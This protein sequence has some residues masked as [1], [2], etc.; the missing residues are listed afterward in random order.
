MLVKTYSQNSITGD[1]AFSR[2]LWSMESFRLW[3][4]MQESVENDR[5]LW[6]V[7]LDLCISGVI[8]WLMRHLCSR[9]CCRMTTA[10]PRWRRR[11][12]KIFPR[13]KL[14]YSRS[15]AEPQ[16]PEWRIRCLQSRKTVREW[17]HLPIMSPNDV[18]SWFLNRIKISVFRAN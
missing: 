3:N 16:S 6:I 14:W 4:S 12:D 11:T 13:P 7:V 8:T 2:W 5:N 17:H 9:C 15:S 18:T 1:V 10:D